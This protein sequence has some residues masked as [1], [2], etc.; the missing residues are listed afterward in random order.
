MANERKR[1]EEDSPL[2]R[3]LVAF[4]GR[5]CLVN[6][7]GK[8][9][10][11]HL[12]E[13]SSNSVFANLVPIN[14]DL[15]T[16]I[17]KQPFEVDIP[18]VLARAR[19]LERQ[20]Q[21]SKAYG[22]YR[23]LSWHCIKVSDLNA[24]AQTMAGCLR[25]LRPLGRH[26]LV[27]DVLLRSVAQLLLPSYRSMHVGASSWASICEE[28]GSYLRENRFLYRFRRWTNLKYEFLSLAEVRTEY[29]L[30]AI[31]A[32]RHAAFAAIESGDPRRA[33]RAMQSA[34]NLAEENNCLQLITSRKSND[35]YLMREL[36]F[37]KKWDEL[38]QQF[39]DSDREGH[40]FYN[41]DVLRTRLGES[42][43]LDIDTWSE[44]HMQS[45]RAAAH[46]RQGKKAQAEEKI[47]VFASMYKGDRAIRSTR[48]GLMIDLIPSFQ[49]FSVQHLW[50]PVDPDSLRSVDHSYNSMLRVLNMLKTLKRVR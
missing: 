25:C 20:S 2:E 15:N 13:K 43:Y 8:G 27:R 45:L 30:L 10:W 26:D 46:L 11:H 22:C 5:S 1:V 39:L 3:Q 18:F 34:V 47:E 50:V 28:I 16:Q 4:Y 24:S 29:F 33:Q 9:Q 6:G 23:L 12:D 37:A 7:Y 19:L 17:E 31:Q 14:G 48:S 21:F 32:R 36:F 49:K 44:C 42:T 40:F 35:L 38:Q 41:P